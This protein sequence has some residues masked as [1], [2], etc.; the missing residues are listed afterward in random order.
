MIE[1]SGFD[2]NSPVEASTG[3]RLIHVATINKQTAV[4]N[5]LISIGADLNIKN[6]DLSHLSVCNAI[7]SE[8]TE[9]ALSLIDA[10]V[11]VDS[12][13]VSGTTDF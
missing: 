3:L 13:S 10:G 7:F 12:V 2:V 11:D 8:D 6:S 4:V 1:M 9:A 5:Y